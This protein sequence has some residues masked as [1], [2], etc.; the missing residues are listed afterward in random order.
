MW[1]YHVSHECCYCV[2]ARV[3]VV[4]YYISALCNGYHVSALLHCISVLYKCY[5]FFIALYH[6][7]TNC[8][9]FFVSLIFLCFF[10]FKVRL[11]NNFFLSF[12]ILEGGGGPFLYKHFN[13]L[14]AF[15]QV[16][17]MIFMWLW[18]GNQI[19]VCC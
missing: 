2:S 9:F 1:R 7:I 10:F 11:K 8:F 13:C 12:N 3:H 16:V 15:L 6:C 19:Q 18:L 5:V 4:M 17:I 14:Q